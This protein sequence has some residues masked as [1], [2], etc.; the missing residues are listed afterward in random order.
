MFD[1]MLWL[2]LFAGW[3]VGSILG[4]S[5]GRRDERDAAARAGVAE[6][7]ANSVTG[8]VRFVYKKVVKEN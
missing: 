6:Y 3:L 4:Y 1:S 5:R 7:E 2:G 8:K